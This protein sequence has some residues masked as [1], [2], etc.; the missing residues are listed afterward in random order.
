[1]ARIST[2]NRVVILILSSYPSVSKRN[3]YFYWLAQQLGVLSLFKLGVL[4]IDLSAL[5][6]LRSGVLM[7]CAD[8]S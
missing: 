3:N 2:L 1:M 6:A 7:K 8:H 5:Y 4:I